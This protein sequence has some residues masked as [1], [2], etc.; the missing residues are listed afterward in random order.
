MNHEAVN[1][2]QNKPGTVQDIHTDRQPPGRAMTQDHQQL[3]NKGN[4]CQAGSQE[5]REFKEKGALA[6]HSRVSQNRKPGRRSDSGFFRCGNGILVRERKDLLA[7]FGLQIGYNIIGTVRVQ[8]CRIFQIDQ[9]GINHNRV[10]A[11]GSDLTPA[12]SEQGFAVAGCSAPG[13]HGRRLLQVIET[14]L[15]SH[16]RMLET[17]CVAC[18]LFCHHTFVSP[19]APARK[20][21][22]GSH[23]NASLAAALL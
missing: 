3:G 8:T 20:T 10:L 22:S 4:H 14:A 7:V 9:P 17:P 1:N 21:A 12:V 2:P 6:Q 23:G 19:N 5:S 16:A 15:A 11:G 13:A 18:F